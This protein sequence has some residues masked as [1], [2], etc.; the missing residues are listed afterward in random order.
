MP[1]YSHYYLIL[2]QTVYAHFPA[3]VLLYQL[4]ESSLP[5]V[6]IS[7]LV[8]WGG[9]GGIGDLACVYVHWSSIILAESSCLDLQIVP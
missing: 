1:N 8:E 4:H 3:S 9:R 5:P 2:S 7:I 6:K